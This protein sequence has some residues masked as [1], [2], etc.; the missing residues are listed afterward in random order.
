MPTPI[1]IRTSPNFD[2]TMG[3]TSTEANPEVGQAIKTQAA[4]ALQN[5]APSA[6]NFQ[7]K[8]ESDLEGVDPTSERAIYNHYGFVPR[9][10]QQLVQ[11][12][13]LA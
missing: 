5:A 6:S 13:K 7:I 12:K 2:G 8:F 11:E 9:P 1:N 10:Q 4:Q 3:T